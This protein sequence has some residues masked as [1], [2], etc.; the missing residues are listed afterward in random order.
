MEDESWKIEDAEL[1]R[2][3]FTGDFYD[4]NFFMREA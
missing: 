1:L 2:N 4:A 3:H